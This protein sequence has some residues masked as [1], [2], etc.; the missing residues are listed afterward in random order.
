M[1]IGLVEDHCD[2][3]HFLH[4]LTRSKKIP[5]QDVKLI[6]FDSHPDMMPLV[7]HN[8]L[9]CYSYQQLC[10]HLE[11]EMG[12]S[13]FI[14]PLLYTGQ[15]NSVV[16]VKSKWAHQFKEGSYNFHIGNYSGADGKDSPKTRVSLEHSYYLDEN[17]VE[18]AEML[19]EKKAIDFHVTDSNGLISLTSS[20]HWILDICLDYFS[21]RNP[22]VG[23][24]TALAESFHSKI[25]DDEISLIKETFERLFYREDSENLWSPCTLLERY[26]SKRCF[27]SC[28]TQLIAI[29]ELSVDIMTEL[30]STLRSCY[31][32]ATKLLQ[33]TDYDKMVAKFLL[34]IRDLPVAVRK[35]IFENG[36]RL[37]LPDHYS[38]LDSIDDSIDELIRLLDRSLLPKPVAITIARSS[39]DEYTPPNQVDIIQSKV[40][41]KIIQWL[42]KFDHF[43]DDCP[44]SIQSISRPENSEVISSVEYVSYD[45][46][47]D[48]SVGNNSDSRPKQSFDT[49]I[50][51]HDLRENSFEKAMSMFLNPKI[52]EALA[53]PADTDT[54]RYYKITNKRKLEE[55]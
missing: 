38:A 3:V 33:S 52:Y 26:E 35:Y 53:K 55:L 20:E 13:Q 48:I 8:V 50:T 7:E 49:S 44:E 30:S 29:D 34:L 5:S 12:I 54:L 31:P 41:K 25:S 4:A 17:M 10:T 19:S 37:L 36:N 23:E 1:H 43:S 46:R 40:L 15:L 22:F 14:L 27:E 51:I 9:D 6:H 32:I 24:L 16:W 39:I 21:V 18:N 42:S 47:N 45:S 2:I 28:C 11:G